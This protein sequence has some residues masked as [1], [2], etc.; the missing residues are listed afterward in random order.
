VPSPVEDANGYPILDAIVAWV[1]DLLD[2]A[3]V[4]AD[5]TVTGVNPGSTTVRA[6][7]G[8]L[9][10]TTDVTVLPSPYP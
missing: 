7:L 6:I 8:G 5:G 4:S 1:S 3:T 2:V 10:D 9:S